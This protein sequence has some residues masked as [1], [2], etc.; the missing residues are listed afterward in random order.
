MLRVAVPEGWSQF[1]EAYAVDQFR[2]SVD[3]DPPSTFW[4]SYLFLLKDRSALVG[5]GG[6]KGEPSDGI[7]EVGYEIAPGYQNRGFATEATRGM[8]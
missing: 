2:G 3:E 8:I 4:G 6:Y 5:S 7:V 1:P